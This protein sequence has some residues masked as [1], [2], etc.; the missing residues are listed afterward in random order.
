[1]GFPNARGH[2]LSNRSHA[3]RFARPGWI[4]GG[5]RTTQTD[6]ETGNA[7]PSTQAFVPLVWFV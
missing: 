6:M 5:L 1:M 2:S 4:S 7:N 3:L